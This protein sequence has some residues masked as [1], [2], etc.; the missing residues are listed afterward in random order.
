MKKQQI[1]EDITNKII[2][3][4]DQGV[5]PWQVPFK[6]SNTLQLPHNPVSK[7]RYRGFNIFALWAQGYEDSR[8]MTYK[9]IKEAGGSVQKGEKGT[10]I[11]FWK[12]IKKMEDGEKVIIPLLRYYTVFNMHQTDLDEDM[13]F[14]PSS[15]TIIDDYMK[16]EGVSLLPTI[17]RAYYRPS[18]DCIHLPKDEDFIND[19]HRLSTLFHEAIHSTGHK[20]RLNRLSNDTYHNKTEYSKEE[21]IAEFGSAMLCALTG[22]ATN[23]IIDNSVAYIQSW[24][25]VIKDNPD[26]IYR[27]CQDAQKALD[28]IENKN[29]K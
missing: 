9:Q 3:R 11:I 17:G 7:T 18:S 26:W 12:F 21:L 1:I 10:R 27:A 4:M 5:L 19:D 16:R 24:S 29:F 20:S 25:K 13:Q 23:E 6:K 2:A 8:W 15:H 28:Y 22:T 14:E